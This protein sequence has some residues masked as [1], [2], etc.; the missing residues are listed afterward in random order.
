ML[1]D[2]SVEGYVVGCEESDYFVVLDDW[3]AF[4]VVFCH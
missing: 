4:Y 2:S 1:Y 3:D